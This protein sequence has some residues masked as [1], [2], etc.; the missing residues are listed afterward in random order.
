MRSKLTVAFILL[1][2]FGACADDNLR[3]YGTYTRQ[4]SEWFEGEDIQNHCKDKDQSCFIRQVNDEVHI[5]PTSNGKLKVSVNIVGAN[6]HT[7]SA[8]GKGNFKTGEITLTLPPL[9]GS[10]GSCTLSITMQNNNTITVL[11][12]PFDIC[13]QYCGARMGGFFAEGLQRISTT[14]EANPTVKRD[15]P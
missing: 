15:A 11:G 7:C 1:S 3:L 14:T 13:G 8:E 6:G 9:A 12:E 2:T 10:E 4:H 5:E